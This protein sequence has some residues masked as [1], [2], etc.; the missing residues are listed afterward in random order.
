MLVLA[1]TAATAC[2]NVWQS[3][4]GPVSEVRCIIRG[5]SCFR[6]SARSSINRPTILGRAELA[7]DEEVLVGL[8]IPAEGTQ[9]ETEVEMR[10]GR[11]NI[12]R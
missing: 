4:Q 8:V 6:L 9:R 12:N 2:C 1:C 7:R 11:T 5:Q 3:F 10:L